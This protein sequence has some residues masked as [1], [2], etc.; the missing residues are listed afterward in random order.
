MKIGFIGLG[1]MGSRM[2]ANL[3]KAGVQL[4]VYNR[5]K[6]KADELLAGGAV[7]ADSPRQVARQVDILFT[8]LATPA[9][10]EA[11]ALGP[12]GF[13]DAMRSGSLWVDHSTVNPSFT[14]SMGEEAH[15]RGVRF[16]DAPVA[17]SKIPA[18]TAQ[19]V[20]FAGGEAADVEACRPYFQSVSRA[21]VHVGGVG[22]GSAMKMVNNS[23]LGQTM[24]AFSEA[25]VLGRSL[26]LTQ[27]QL[28]DTLLGSTVVP[29]YMTAKRGKLENDDYSPEF[30]LQ[31]M[32]KD[33]QLASQSAYEQGV[34]LPALNLAKE[35][36]MLAAQNGLAEEDFS[37][38]YAYFSAPGK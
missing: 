10:V 27:Q 37:A 21:V 31:W 14:R 38:V 36:F 35:L 28:L 5:T 34:A 29:P 19:L 15:Q 23:L 7:W 16:V 4:V 2:A 32:Q 33:L 8:M 24:L 18:Q 25:L 11:T 13:L 26:G 6:S 17:G 30:P 20:I 22:S 3:Q 1:I 12:D 9:S